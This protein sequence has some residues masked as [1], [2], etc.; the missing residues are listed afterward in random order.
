MSASSTGSFA[1]PT[2]TARPA[3][4]A[5]ARMLRLELRHNAMLWVLPLA[6]GLFWFITYRKVMALPPLW[7]VRAATTQSGVVADFVTPVAG[8]A[9]WMGSRES[10][11][12]VTDL[13][14]TVARPRFTRLLAAWAATACWAELGF[15]ICLAAVYWQTSRQASWGGPL[16][17]PAAVGAASVAAFA[18]LGFAAGVRIPSRFTAPV[19]AIA[20][21]FV[22]ALSTELIVGSQSYWQVSPIVTGPWDMSTDPGVA[23][24]YPYLPDLSIAQIMF[25]AGLTLAIIAGVLGLPA[26]AG[27]R[28]LRVVSAIAAVVGVA[29]AGTAV[30]LTGSG[31]LGPHGMIAIPALHD[32]ADDR[33]LHFSP[34]CSRTVIPV[35]L[36]PAYSVYLPA[37]SKAL[38]PVLAEIA[39]LPGAPVRISQG[40]ATYRQGPGNSVGISLAGQALAGSPPVYYFLLPDQLAGPSLTVSQF[41]SAVRSDT[42]PTIIVSFVGEVTGGS[43]AQ[44]AVADALAKASGLGPIGAP[45][46]APGRP[47]QP[48]PRTRCAAALRGAQRGVPDQ[49]PY[50]AVVGPSIAAAVE[51]FEALPAQV[52]RAWLQKHLAALREGRVTLK[53]LP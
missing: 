30:V 33:P 40:A 49:Q 15:G 46:F 45:S 7:N 44:Q 27:G 21:F 9:A 41:G 35:C 18:A 3:W 1:L 38:D 23:T 25:L 10:R 39:G 32:A 50:S 19:V 42:G 24:F 53:E 13:M 8:A 14:A 4:P 6:I 5:A 31:S 52:R 12:R 2:R 29:T 11:R 20:A 47:C 28:R 16:W 37:V 36:N 48:G 34:V 17:W 22:I 26:A 51:R 43:Q